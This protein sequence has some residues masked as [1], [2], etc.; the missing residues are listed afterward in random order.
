MVNLQKIGDKTAIGLSGLCLVHCLLLPILLIVLPP[1]TGLLTLNDETFHQWMLFAVIPISFMALLMGH[2][3]H[4]NRFTLLIGATG[5]AILVFTAFIDH[6]TFG[7]YADVIFTV[8]G[9]SIITYAHIRN[10]QLRN[11]RQPEAK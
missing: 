1:I 6:D 10:Y 7:P 5:L 4:R 11:R 8:I 2:R 9:S 3:H